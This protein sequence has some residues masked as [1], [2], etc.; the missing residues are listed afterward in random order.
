MGAP[1]FWLCFFNSGE[2]RI[3]KNRNIRI[4]L[5]F[6]QPDNLLI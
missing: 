3:N 6:S 2:K 4:R 1:V 5:W